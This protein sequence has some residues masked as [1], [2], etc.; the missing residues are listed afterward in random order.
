MQK[1]I[2]G[3]IASLLLVGIGCDKNKACCATA[4]K[5]AAMTD[6]CAMCPGVQTAKADGTCPKCGAKVKG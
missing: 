6:D 4:D 3:V 2:V 1:R 5:S